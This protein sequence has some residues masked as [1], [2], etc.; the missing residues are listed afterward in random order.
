MA[1]PLKFKTPKE[2]EKKINAYF[3][4]CDKTG[5]PYTITG[6][7][8]S[9]GAT[10]QTLLNYEEREGFFDTI[11]KAKT[12]VEHY[13]EKRLFGPSPTGAIF[14]LKNFGWSDKPRKNNHGGKVEIVRLIDDIQ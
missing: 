6:L 8:L 13:A 14:A 11:K 4:E 1:R 3:D 2:I 7:A 12:R 9:L 10:R 5:D